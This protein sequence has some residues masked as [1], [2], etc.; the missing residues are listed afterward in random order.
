L[1]AVELCIETNST[2]HKQKGEYIMQLYWVEGLFA[3]KQAL[4]KSRKS[5]EMGLEPYA[6]SIWA[7]DPNEAIRIATQELNGGQWEEGPKVSDATEEM[8]MRALGA[9]E[10]PGFGSIRKKRKR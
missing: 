10:L 7:N 1:L 9:P 5:K 2:V 6:K 4:L 3:T 8:R